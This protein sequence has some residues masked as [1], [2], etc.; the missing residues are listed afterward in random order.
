LE[1]DDVTQASTP[2]RFTHGC[3]EALPQS[4]AELR[5][6]RMVITG[7]RFAF[8]WSVDELI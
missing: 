1:F 4:L 3:L 2:V 8:S 5:S 6:K 7:C